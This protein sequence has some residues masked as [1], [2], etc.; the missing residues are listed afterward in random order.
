MAGRC[1]AGLETTLQRN[2]SPR[3]LAEIGLIAY[4]KEKVT[5]LPEWDLN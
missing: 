1:Y 5:E 2:K 4:D 3:S